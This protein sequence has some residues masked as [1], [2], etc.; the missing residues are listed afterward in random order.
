MN[1]SSSARKNSQ[2]EVWIWRNSASISLQYITTHAC[3]PVVLHGTSRLYQSPMSKF[4]L[5]RFK[6]ATYLYWFSRSIFCSEADIT[7]LLLNQYRSEQKS[8]GV[9][10][11]LRVHNDCNITE[12]HQCIL[13]WEI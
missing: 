5:P 7:M 12:G 9:I 3:S 1:C 4:D 8:A 6:A 10:L 2:L 11:Q 13:F